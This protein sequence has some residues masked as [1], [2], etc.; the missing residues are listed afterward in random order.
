MKKTNIIT[1]VLFLFTMHI[2]FCQDI[3]FS[4][5]E[6]SPLQLNPALTGFDGGM[7]AT[8]NYRS[9]WGSVA[10]PYTTSAASFDMRLPGDPPQ[11]SG[12]LAFGLGFY[13]DQAG[14]DRV[15][16]NSLKLNVAYHVFLDKEQKL[17]AGIAAGLGQR[18]LKDQG[19]WGT[20]YTGMAFD[21]L[22]P[23][24]EN[25][26]NPQFSFFDTGGGIVYG[27]EQ[28]NRKRT[29]NNAV[30]IGVA[31]YHWNRPNYSF[32]NTAKERLFMRTSIFANG[33]I[34]LGTLD[35]TI[36]PGIYFHSQAVMREFLIGGYARYIFDEE[37]QGAANKGSSIAI[38][39]FN[40]NND[41]VIAKFLLGFSG[42]NIGLSYDFNTS[43]LA[44]MSNGRGGT[45]LF[46]QWVINN[47]SKTK[48]RTR[49]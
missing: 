30:N 17:S 48:S 25:I 24:M 7:R 2:A 40:R 43:E 9:Q 22:A 1:L 49:I 27:Y 4:Q 44:N 13:N 5:P 28:N 23:T 37:F 14:D 6:Y 12:F 35:F 31:L 39:L 42:V 29:F 21:P 20:Q 10:T 32:F 36:E 34:R 26:G 18:N 45:E 33:V 11:Q 41:A 47:S 3:H 8:V 15:A 16:S 38:G 46:L 19:T